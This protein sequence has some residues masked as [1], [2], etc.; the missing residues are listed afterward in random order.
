M[1]PA[2]P[3][4]P[5]HDPRYRDVQPWELPSSES[6]KDTAL[7]LWPCWQRSIAPALRRNE[8]VLVVAHGNSLRA[9][10]KYLNGISDQA[11]ADLD[12]PYG[13]PLI[14][15]LDQDPIPLE[16]NYLGEV[17]ANSRQMLAQESLLARTA[18]HQARR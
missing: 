9:L 13:I 2:D 17:S 7:R 14:Y 18:V 6:L 10:V 3:R 12:I 11:I 5:R 4:H 1:D 16:N 15:D 8:K